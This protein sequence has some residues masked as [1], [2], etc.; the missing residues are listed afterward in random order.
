MVLEQ[1]IQRPIDRDR[2]RALAGFRRDAVDQLI[3]AERAAVAGENFEDAP[4]PRR[5]RDAL[6][7][8]QRQRRLE[9]LR[10][11][12]CCMRAAGRVVRGRSWAGPR[13]AR[14]KLSYLQY[15][16]KLEPKAKPRRTG[17]T[18]GAFRRVS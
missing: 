6:V 4:P 13:R 1:E 5:Q 3:G 17:G 18:A 16:A 15:I 11:A 10:L 14:V 9:R 2:G 12:P 7:A 8:A